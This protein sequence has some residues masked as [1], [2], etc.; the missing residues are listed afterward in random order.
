MIE[1]CSTLPTIV[2]V[3]EN[4]NDNGRVIH[5]RVVRAFH[6]VDLATSGAHGALHPAH[7]VLRDLLVSVAVPDLNHVRIDVVAETPRTTF[8]VEDLEQVAV[9]TA[10]RLGM[11]GSDECV[12]K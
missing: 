2:D 4:L 10:G 9:Q 1:S 8:V 6:D 12:C 5:Q 11:R 3:L 7:R